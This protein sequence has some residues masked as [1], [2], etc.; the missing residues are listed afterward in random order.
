MKPTLVYDATCAL[1]A[2]YQRFIENR[3]GDRIAYEGSGAGAEE[4]QYRDSNGLTYTGTRAIEKFVSDFPE[5]RDF[6]TMLPQ[7]LRIVGVRIPG[8]L[9]VAGVKAIYKASGVVRK[10]YQVIHKGCNCGG[11]RK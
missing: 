2:N 3:L 6:N 1:C 4:V 7:A 9:P 10:G 8:K 11:K 5:I